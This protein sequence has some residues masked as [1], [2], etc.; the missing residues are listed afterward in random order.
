MSFWLQFKTELHFFMV[1]LRYSSLIRRFSQ[2]QNALVNFGAGP[3]GR[4]DWINV[5]GCEAENVNCIWDCRYRLPLPE[6]CARGVFTEHF[7][8]HLDYQLDA[9]AFLKECLRIMKVGAVIRIIVPDAQAFLKA[10][11]APGWDEMIKLRLTGGD[12]KDIGYGLLYETKMQVVNV[13][14]R[15]FDEH[16]YAYDFETLRALLVSA[17]FEDVK[18]T[19][20]GVSRLPELAIDMKWRARESLYVEAVKS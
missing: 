8:E 10:Y 5:D 14:F 12:R 16:K 7:L 1:R 17:G 3:R 2:T 19:E 15:Q 18:R 4:S 20:F 9:P 11:T 13:V 6:A